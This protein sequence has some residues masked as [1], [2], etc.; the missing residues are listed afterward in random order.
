M[1]YLTC[2]YLRHRLLRAKAGDGAPDA[3]SKVL[4]CLD[5]HVSLLGHGLLE[6]E[7]KA[8]P[9]QLFHDCQN[10]LQTKQLGFKLTL[11]FL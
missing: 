1:A 11:N 5:Q 7:R 4:R 6:G 10:A 3:E 8:L 9:V 2:E